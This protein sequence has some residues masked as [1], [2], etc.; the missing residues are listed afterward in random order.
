[1]AD[2]IPRWWITQHALV[3]FQERFA[4]GHTLDEA[5]ALL[6]VISVDAIDVGAA[7]RGRMEL[8]AD[9]P[10]VRFVVSNDVGPSGKPSLLTV[11]DAEMF[12]GRRS[13]PNALRRAA[14]GR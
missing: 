3:R 11:L 12:S 1:M 9:W 10:A 4:P 8:H 5:G 6:R 7:R 13:K 14:R 2:R